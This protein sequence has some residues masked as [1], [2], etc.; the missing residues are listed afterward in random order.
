MPSRGIWRPSTTRP[1]SRRA[2]PRVLLGLERRRGRGSRPCRSAPPSPSPACSGVMPGPSSWPCSGSPA[3]SRSVSRAPSP[4]GVMPGVE[5]RSPHRAGRAPP[6]RGARRRPRPCTRCPATQPA[7]AVE[8]RRGAP[9]SAATAAASGD[10]RARAARAP[11]APAPRAPHASAVMSSTSHSPPPWTSRPRRSASTSGAVFDAF[12][13]TRKSL[14]VDPPHDDVVDDVRV[15]GVEQVRVL[16]P[17]GLDAVEV[18]GERPLQRGER[19]GAVHAHRAEVRD[20]EHHRVARGTP[21]APRARRVYWIGISQPPNGDHARA[22]RAVL[23]VERAVT[24]RSTSGRLGGRLLGV[25]RCGAD[26]AGARSSGSGSVRADRRR[27]AATAARARTS[28]AG[29]GSR[30]GRAP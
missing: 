22:E 25:G 14:G 30:A 27:R 29:A 7:R 5:Q 11:R 24:Q 28:R 6:A 18:V 9:R 26:G 16:R 2:T 1:R 10:D 12:G 20:V 4:A 8:R 3:S 21:G 23:G 19:A 15:V 13:I 17:P